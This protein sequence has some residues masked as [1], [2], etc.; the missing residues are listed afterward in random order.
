MDEDFRVWFIPPDHDHQNPYLLYVANQMAWDR[1][2]A[3]LDQFFA[4]L[5]ARVLPT[6][7]ITSTNYS[8]LLSLLEQL[9]DPPTLEQFRV[10]EQERDFMWVDGFA[11]LA[12]VSGER[13]EAGTNGFEDVDNLERIDYVRNVGT[14]DEICRTMNASSIRQ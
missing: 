7:A 12:S 8:I 2:Y 11:D 5:W 4:Y 10:V 9:R 1:G 14:M 3:D 13:K 6:V